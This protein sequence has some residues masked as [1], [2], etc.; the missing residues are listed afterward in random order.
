MTAWPSQPARPLSRSRGSGAVNLMLVPFLGMA[1]IVRVLG[2]DLSG[3]DSQNSGTFNLSAAIAVL[4][5]AV[6]IFVLLRRRRGLRA[7]VPAV[8]WLLIWTAI[9]VNTNGASTET[10][11]EGVREISVLAVAV[12]VYNALGA[13]SAVTATRLVQIAGLVPA[14]LALY[15]L[16]THTGRDIAGEVR[17]YGTFAHP[18]SAAMYF[19]IATTA[20]LWQALKDG[21]RRW[22][23]LFVVLFSAAL[24]STFSIDGLI[25]LIVMLVALGALR[26]DS[27]EAKL[28]P[29]A[30]AALVAVAFFAT[31]LGSQRLTNESSTSVRTAEQGKPNSSLAWRLNKWKLLVPEWERSP[32]V[33]LGLG[34]T[35]TGRRIPGNAFA[36]E[37]P[38]N[39]YIR[40]LVETG[41]VGLAILGWA[42]AIL[43]RRLF[44]Q[45]SLSV[46]SHP[47]ARGAARLA[48]VI[49]V[50]CLV[51]S[52]AE[53]T[54]LNSP[55]CYA[56]ALIIAAALSMPELDA[57]PAAGVNGA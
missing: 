9:A 28:I 41:I 51:N 32:L 42:L 27:S 13:V 57:A 20:S 43:I 17:A 44:R 26:R 52:F 33:G 29:W 53:S 3:P 6:A 47:G 48:I 36:G 8:L 31:P 12:I 34:T 10:L 46:A 25:T 56:A 15:Q 40:Y 5:I 19:A 37:S 22:D 35:V 30:L 1:L 14:V 50:G 24:V 18:D 38:H 16:S 45:R 7:T 2:D 55:T 11:R 39:E 23:A 54:F 21:R 49:I 4:F